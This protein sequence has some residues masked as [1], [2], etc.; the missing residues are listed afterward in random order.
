[1]AWSR[2][3]TSPLPASPR[4]AAPQ[5]PEERTEPRAPFIASR[6]DHVVPSAATNPDVAPQAAARP[7]VAAPSQAVAHGPL[8]HS[9]HSRQRSARFADEGTIQWKPVALAVGMPG[10]G[11]ALF[12]AIF[13]LSAASNVDALPE[14]DQARA[15]DLPIT[16]SNSPTEERYASA[17]FEAA[18]PEEQADRT[19]SQT[20]TEKARLVRLKPLPVSPPASPSAEQVAIA[21]LP[22]ANLAS[23]EA[24]PGPAAQ[25]AAANLPLPNRTI[26]STIGRIG[27]PCGAVATSAA[28]DGGAPGV[29]KITCTSGHSYQASPVNGRY[30][31][32]RWR[33]Q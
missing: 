12:G 11:I 2:P 25:P 17:D 29:F 8:M 30:R 4:P 20:S 6:S 5:R 33:N 27:Y 14:V 21:S 32:R 31:F 16:V 26:A 19:A 7:P 28:V 23:A 22:E 1:M 24:E 15:A 9:G 18:D 13:G 10:L 3:R